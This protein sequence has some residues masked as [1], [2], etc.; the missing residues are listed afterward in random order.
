MLI[1]RRV[2]KKRIKAWYIFNAHHLLAWH[3]SV[4]GLQNN[5]SDN[6][7]NDNQENKNFLKKYDTTNTEFLSQSP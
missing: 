1:L 6:N 7:N 2:P 5:N 4:I 3:T